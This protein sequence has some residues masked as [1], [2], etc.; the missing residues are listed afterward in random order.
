MTF[1]EK[2]KTLRTSANLTQNQLAEKTH[3]S[4]K[5]LWFYEQ[6]E[7]KPRKGS[8]E[9]IAEFFKVPVDFLQNESPDD[10]E[11]LAEYADRENG[12]AEADRIIKD[13]QGLFAG[14]KLSEEDR[15]TVMLT[16]Q[17]IY[18]EVKENRGKNNK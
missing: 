1:G 17:K 6:D 2:L 9:V 8:Y 5:S 10:F 4:A 15:D 16:L 18:W 7:R 11:K 3:I 12:K 14:G 13:V